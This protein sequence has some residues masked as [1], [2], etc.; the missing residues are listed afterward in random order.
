M[1]LKIES[2]DIAYD[3]IC[4]ADMPGEARK[5]FDYV[6][7]SPMIDHY[8]LRFVLYKGTYYDLHDMQQ[9]V[10]GKQ[11]T[12]PMGWAMYVEPEHPFATWQLVHSDSF[13]SGVLF[14]YVESEDN[15]QVNCA[16]Y[17][18]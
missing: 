2:D 16:T 6:G 14:R 8:T 12:L 1:D 11:H 13:F 3:L 9:I 5:D 10:V 15:E 17:Y 4:Y 18:S 7:D